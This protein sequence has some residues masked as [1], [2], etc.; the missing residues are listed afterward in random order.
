MPTDSNP[1]ARKEAVPTSKLWFGSAAATGAW[2][3]LGLSDMFITWRA[4]LHEEQFGGP[5]AHPGARMPFFFC[6][7]FLL[8]LAVVAGVMS[9]RNWKR[10]S[11]LTAL[12]RAEATERKEFM[13]LAGLFISFTLGVGIV[14]LCLPLFIIQ[15]CIRAR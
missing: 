4:C 12:L 11:G 6:S 8:A 3:G 15:M 10:L 9:Y 14:W 2:F 5:S 7:S 13:A 1:A